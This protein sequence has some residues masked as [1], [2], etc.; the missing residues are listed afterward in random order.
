MHRVPRLSFCIAQDSSRLVSSCVVFACLRLRLR[1]HLPVLRSPSSLFFP[2]RA[3]ATA[4]PLRHPSAQFHHLHHIYHFCFSTAT[5]S[6]LGHHHPL[7][8]P[9]TSQP[10]SSAPAPCYAPVHI[11]P[12]RRTW[13]RAPTP[14]SIS[15]CETFVPAICAA[16][17]RTSHA[18]DI[19][20]EIHS[21]APRRAQIPRLACRLL[22]A[23]T[24]VALWP[25]PTTVTRRSCCV[26]SGPCDAICAPPGNG[27]D[28]RAE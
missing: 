11:S 20:F 12:E 4:T 26:R 15:V 3:A 25:N 21:L 8:I 13:P 2:R 10:V 22:P 14:R 28:E 24:P 27:P 17:V 16:A 19:D 23:S 18:S 7:L 5:A 6:I 1:L 9:S